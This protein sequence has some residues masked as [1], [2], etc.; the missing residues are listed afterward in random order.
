MGGRRRTLPAWAAAS[1]A[2]LVAVAAGVPVPLAAPGRPQRPRG[3]L[4]QDPL[5]AN[6]FDVDARQMD[7]IP[8]SPPIRAGPKCHPKCS[9]ECESPGC[10]SDCKPKCLAPKC[11]TACDKLA[12]NRCQRTCEPPDCAVVC[13]KACSTGSCPECTTVCGKPKCTMKCGTFCQSKCA[14]PVCEWQCN[15]DKCE[16]PVCKMTCEK[17]SICGLGDQ[18]ALHDL[19]GVETDTMLNKVVMGRGLAKVPEDIMLPGALMAEGALTPDA[20]NPAPGPG[21]APSAVPG[22][23]P[24]PAPGS[25]PSVAAL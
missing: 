7:E 9:W 1:A 19:P 10:N 23:A 2:C 24:G 8:N 22:P 14:D 17:A 5:S 15:V 12:L 18:Q 21:P 25:A 16:K 6:F 13:P 11:H 3:L 20:L 4:L